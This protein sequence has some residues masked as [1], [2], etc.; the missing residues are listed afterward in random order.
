MRRVVLCL[1]FAVSAGGL[2]PSLAAQTVHRLAPAD[3]RVTIASEIVY[4]VGGIAAEPW[5]SFGRIDQVGFDGG[6]RL[7]VLDGQNQ[8]LVV[9]G[10]SGELIRTIGRRGSGP[11]E[12]QAP[13]RMFVLSDG[14][15]VVHDVVRRN[16]Q[17]FGPDGA[18]L[19]EAQQP[20]E[21]GS[22]N[23]FA[24][25]GPTTA[26]ATPRLVV[27]DGSLALATDLDGGAPTEIPLYRV[28]LADGGKA[29]RIGGA[30][31]APRPARGPFSPHAFAPQLHWAQVG[32]RIAI[33][34]SVTYDVRV[35]DESGSVVARLRRPLEPREP[36]RADRER[37]R[38]EARERF[39]SPEGQPRVVGAVSGGGGGDA[40]GR[41]DVMRRI[42]QGLRDMTFAERIPV[43]LGLRG[44][45]DARL[46]ITRAAPTWGDAG[47]VDLV[48]LDGRYI[49][50]VNAPGFRVPDAFGPRGL[51]AYIEADELETPVVVV[52]RIGIEEPSAGR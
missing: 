41:G 24:M 32:S 4:R 10:P 16:F 6:G 23:G 45:M 14:G 44:D 18:L 48:R 38:A 30:W 33:V 9:V 31:V 1:C 13:R 19:G 34:D 49:G 51:A 7:Y 11:G 28:E 26:F 29:T 17:R 12:F 5:A 40:G 21:L 20:R 43:V 36:T 15:V 46:W 2:V 27:V 25:L 35:I 50:T 42:E 52:R 47:P 8:R 37:A 39:I 3:R 22:P